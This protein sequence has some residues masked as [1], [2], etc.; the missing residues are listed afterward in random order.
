[1][2]QNLRFPDAVRT[3]QIRFCIVNG[4]TGEVD[5]DKDFRTRMQT[6]FRNDSNSI[7]SWFN[8]TKDQT[9]VLMPKLP[10][11]LA[12]ADAKFAFTHGMSGEEPAIFLENYQ[13]VEEF[14]DK[15]P[16]A[17]LVW[18][19]RVDHN[20]DDVWS[21]LDIA[22]VEINE[23]RL[24]NAWETVFSFV[25]HALPMIFPFERR[26]LLLN[27]VITFCSTQNKP[28][29]GYVKDS[30]KDKQGTNLGYWTLE[31]FLEMGEQD[32]RN[33]EMWDW[34]FVDISDQDFARLS[35]FVLP[36]HPD[37]TDE[38]KKVTEVPGN[39]TSWM[40]HLVETAIRR[41]WL[42]F[43]R[44]AAREYMNIVM[45][46]SVT[47]TASTT[48]REQRPK[49]LLPLQH[50]IA[51]N[52][53]DVDESLRPQQQR[54][55]L[56]RVGF[57]SSAHK[58][59]PDAKEQHSA[60]MMM[61]I[62]APE[63]QI[64]SLGASPGRIICRRMEFEVQ[65]PVPEENKLPFDLDQMQ[66]IQID[67]DTNLSWKLSN[68]LCHFMVDGINYTSTSAIIGILFCVDVPSNLPEGAL[69]VWLRF[70]ILD[71]TTSP[72]GKPSFKAISTIFPF[73]VDVHRGYTSNVLFGGYRPQPPSA[74]VYNRKLPNKQ[75]QKWAIDRSDGLQLMQINFLER[76]QR[77]QNYENQFL[78]Q[79]CKQRRWEQTQ[80]NNSLLFRY[81]YESRL[82][83]RHQMST[84]V[85]LKC[86][87]NMTAY[88]PLQST[89]RSPALYM[90][91]VSADWDPAMDI[92][93][94]IYEIETPEMSEENYMQLFRQ[95]Q[96]DNVWGPT[97]HAMN[98]QVRI[99]FISRPYDKH[100]KSPITRLISPVD[101]K[102]QMTLRAAFGISDF[103]L[104]ERIPSEIKSE[105][106]TRFPWMWSTYGD[107]YVNRRAQEKLQNMIVEWVAKLDR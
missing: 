105:G 77:W 28:P 47:M 2:L 46:R 102:W 81:Y 22:D 10:T 71:S 90:S 79:S 89:I 29:R 78:I 32:M 7:L 27:S 36:L 4:N 35:G 1:M 97:A 52:L 67:P 17:I 20:E 12:T 19:V 39:W 24:N 85:N 101:E 75:R 45:S 38:W 16:S 59:T 63:K 40:Y 13:Q 34:L 53:S 57:G 62:W 84:E 15:A 98:A 8:T 95:L 44:F 87:A 107:H 69:A 86:M 56:P 103:I 49:Q 73:V 42:P 50:H 23:R 25:D 100:N 83:C 92:W 33:K 80:D 30:E 6:V 26:E 64:N 54:Q 3:I 82:Q 48:E 21:P 66:L 88:N 93:A 5:T 94:W 65:K 104:V 55:Q 106:D 11:P 99:V 60:A 51:L 37:P 96:E 76:F 91:N 68:R 31:R 70:G 74:Q 58:L 18:I 14:I 43:H 9:S 61:K 41:T 72:V